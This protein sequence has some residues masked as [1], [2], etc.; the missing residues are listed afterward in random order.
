MS[1]RTV[2]WGHWIRLIAAITVSFGA[3]C[4]ISLL[5]LGLVFFYTWAVLVTIQQEPSVGVLVAAA[6]LT[7]V[8][9][10]ALWWVF[11][12][13]FGSV[14]RPRPDVIADVRK[15]VVIFAGGPL[16]VIAVTVLVDLLFGS[17]GLWPVPVAFVAG[18]LVVGVHQ[19]QLWGG[20]RTAKA[21]D[22]V[23]PDAD[24][25]VEAPEVR[26]DVVARVNR[27][28]QQAGVPSPDVRLVQTESHRVA[29][30]GYRSA[31]AELL[32]SPEVVA[33]LDGDELDAVL[34]HELAH[35][36]N[37]DS[38]VLTLLSLPAENATDVLTKHRHPLL[39]L[40]LGPIVLLCNLTIALVARHREYLADMAGARLTSPAALASALDTLDES[41]R[42]PATDLRGVTAFNIVPPESEGSVRSDDLKWVRVR[43][44]RLQYRLFGTHP[45][46][47]A[48]VRR[49]RQ[50]E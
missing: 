50:L 9:V 17:A 5:E 4:F 26:D 30:V 39:V 35:L 45:E 11:A 13:L 25:A 10:L 34:A 36:G 48:R 42:R 32:V 37:R 40:V 1:V 2:Y 47:E 27:L 12:R 41:S 18:I 8:G 6:T 7:L 29:T 19:Y 28:A 33:Q 24:R 23:A 44:R 15:L 14:D 31:D 38:A 3:L 22:A 21:V 20:F 49:L 43:Y 16:A 46:T